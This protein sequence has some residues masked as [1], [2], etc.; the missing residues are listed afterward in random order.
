MNFKAILSALALVP[1][2]LTL[3]DET[4]KSVETSLDGFSGADKLK[5]ALA[6]LD[7]YL[8]AFAADVAVLA[9]LKTILTP[10]V[11][12]AVAAFNVAGLFKKV[13]KTTAG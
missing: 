8:D 9:S 13:D 3:V 10:L 11:N 5:A 12:A 4:V 7:V 2:L 1:S 6:K